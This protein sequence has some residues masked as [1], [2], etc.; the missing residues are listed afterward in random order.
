MLLDLNQ[1]NL[2]ALSQNLDIV[3]FINLFLTCKKLYSLR[4]DYSKFLIIIEEYKKYDKKNNIFDI[5]FSS[6][7]N[8]NSIKN[9]NDSNYIKLDSEIITKTGLDKKRLSNTCNI[10]G[11]YFINYNRLISPPDNNM[12]INYIDEIIC[13]TNNYRSSYFVKSC[14]KN[15]YNFLKINCYMSDINIFDI[16]EILY[17]IK[18]RKHRKIYDILNNLNFRC[19]ESDADITYTLSVFLKYIEILNGHN[20]KIIIASVLYSYI[21]FNINKIKKYEKLSK[22]IEYKANE[23]ISVID[24]SKIYPKYLKKFIIDKMNNVSCLLAI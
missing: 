8:F 4:K 1:D 7:I 18:Y 3:S 5:L 13:T 11:F 14:K 2:F 19:S 17:H 10:F 12:I 24:E 16:C 20:N 9:I 22:T 6:Y 15:L 23:F 21:E